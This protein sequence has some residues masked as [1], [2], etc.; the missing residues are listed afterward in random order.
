LRKRAI[1]MI[2]PTSKV[3]SPSGL[4]VAQR[5]PETFFCPLIGSS[6]AARTLS[7]EIVELKKRVHERRCSPR[8]GPPAPIA[9]S[10]PAPKRDKLPRR[11]RKRIDRYRRNKHT[12]V[13]V[14]P[15]RPPN[16]PRRTHDALTFGRRTRVRV[17]RL[18]AVLLRWRRGS[19]ITP[20]PTWEAGI[21]DGKSGEKKCLALFR[22][23]RAW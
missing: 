12:A 20:M 7:G 11:G 16:S 15:K 14:H 4:A 9:P 17:P 6:T 19:F 1:G 13:P 8:L 3:G 2:S 23:S 18:I 5:P 21:K 10:A 22:L